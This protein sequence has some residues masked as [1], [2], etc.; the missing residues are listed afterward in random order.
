VTAL[1]FVYQA[2]PTRVG[3]RARRVSFVEDGRAV[4][5]CRSVIT[6]ASAPHDSRSAPITNTPINL[7]RTVAD[8]LDP[9][10][11]A[12]NLLNCGRKSLYREV[13]GLLTAPKAPFASRV[14]ATGCNAV[15]MSEAQIALSLLYCE[16]A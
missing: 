3:F 12:F 6:E 14:A 15:N 1:A 10:E 13:V 9:R 16:F 4:R 7:A 8:Q 5:D 11:P 2:S